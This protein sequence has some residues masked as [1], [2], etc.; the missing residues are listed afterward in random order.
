MSC[1]VSAAPRHADVL[2]IPRTTTL[3][4]HRCVTSRHA[5]E[6][7]HVGC[8]VA[9]GTIMKAKDKRSPTR[10]TAEAPRPAAATPVESA[11][12]VRGKD[13]EVRGSL[14]SLASL[15]KRVSNRPTAMRAP[16]CLTKENRPPEAWQAVTSE[17]DA[18]AERR[19]TEARG[20]AVRAFTVASLGRA[21]AG[22]GAKQAEAR[23]SR[24]LSSAGLHVDVR[25]VMARSGL[26]PEVARALL[27]LALTPVREES[28][29]RLHATLYEVPRRPS[30][31]D[32]LS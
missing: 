23:T 11:V 13:A 2:S 20:A 19:A 21:S 27:D 29:R 26:G 22:L 14:G 12:H 5:R 16:T 25:D 4:S 7:W 32:P 28:E 8:S 30:K 6:E 31:D 9:Y 1:T 3:F 18:G 15:S 10:P 24:L 17:V